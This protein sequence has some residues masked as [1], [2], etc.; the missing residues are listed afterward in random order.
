[1]E[2]AMKHFDDESLLEY[3]IKHISILG[4]SCFSTKQNEHFPVNG[5]EID[6]IFACSIKHIKYSKTMN[7]NNDDNDDDHSNER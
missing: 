1:M 6:G 3:F 2:K 4:H 5:M 7:N